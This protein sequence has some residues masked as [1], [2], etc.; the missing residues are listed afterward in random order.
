MSRSLDADADDKFEY[1]LLPFDGFSDCKPRKSDEEV[2][3][4]ALK[5]SMILCSIG[6]TYSRVTI[7]S[8]ESLKFVIRKKTHIAQSFYART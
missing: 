6:T 7:E 2:I 1:R 5:Y 4:F 8:F 3:L